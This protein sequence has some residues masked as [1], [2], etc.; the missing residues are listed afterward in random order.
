MNTD[1]DTPETDDIHEL[2]MLFRLASRLMAR[3]YHSHDHGPHTQ[4]HV[5]NLVRRRGAVA[6]AELLELLDMRAAS[7]SELLAKLEKNGRIFRER[8]PDD[9]R[10]FIVR[11]AATAGG[12]ENYS[13]GRPEAPSQ[14]ARESA[15]AIFGVLDLEER[16][17]LW[18]LLQKLA[19]PLRGHCPSGPPWA[20]GGNGRGRGQQRC[21]GRG[22]ER[23]RGRGRCGLPHHDEGTKE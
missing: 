4:E 8:N 17:Q 9:R 20:G 1:P 21:G 7:L 5:L 23:G 6:Q 2:A 18:A 11:P 14:A 15:E 12:E 10:G 19:A 3:A 16:R 13:Q 22:G